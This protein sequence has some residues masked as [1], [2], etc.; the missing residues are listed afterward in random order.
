VAGAPPFNVLLTEVGL[1]GSIVGVEGPT[2]RVCYHSLE[3]RLKRA[4]S[5]WRADLHILRVETRR[6]VGKSKCDITWRY[7]IS[8]TALCLA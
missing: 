5:C 7:E 2:Q 3:A 1:K 6:L 4:V 8:T